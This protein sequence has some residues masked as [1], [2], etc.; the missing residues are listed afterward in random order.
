MW[1]PITTVRKVRE[2]LTQ[3][4]RPE[5]KENR[6]PG[7]IFANKISKNRGQLPNANDKMH[8]RS[9]ADVVS[10]G[11]DEI[12]TVKAD[13]IGNGWLYRSNVATFTEYRNPEALYESFLKKEGNSVTIRRMGH[14][15]PLPPEEVSPLGYLLA[16][17]EIQVLGRSR[18]IE[19][20]HRSAAMESVLRSPLAAMEGAARRRRARPLA[21]SFATRRP[22]CSLARKRGHRSPTLVPH[23]LVEDEATR[24]L[25][26]GYS[27]L[28]LRKTP[29]A[30]HQRKTQLPARWRIACRPLLLVHGL[31]LVAIL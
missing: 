22:L 9:Y 6:V 17:K 2:D 21:G 16:V 24:S 4:K 11:R 14:K 18:A 27:S 12:P 30:T 8:G 7:K 23:S 29:I 15:Q 20:V 13:P 5:L 10:H 28:G 3:Q 19:E 1:V 26:D 31:S 25:E